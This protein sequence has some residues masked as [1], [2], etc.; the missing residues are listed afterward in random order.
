MALTHRVSTERNQQ[1]QAKSKLSPNY[2]ALKPSTPHVH[3]HLNREEY[4]DWKPKVD[5]MK[6]C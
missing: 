6:A 3:Q 5:T 1:K 2:S 4:R